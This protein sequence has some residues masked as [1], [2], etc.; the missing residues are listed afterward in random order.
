MDSGTDRILDNR[1]INDATQ[2][3]RKQVR[4]NYVNREEWTECIT[5]LLNDHKKDFAN[6]SIGKVRKNFQMV[7][8]FSSD[9]KSCCSEL[10]ILMQER[11]NPTTTVFSLEK[12][13][14]Y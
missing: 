7:D 1:K 14:F 5:S 9:W 6:I 3:I 10:K 12:Y 2:R 13:A 4:N 11:D 8:N